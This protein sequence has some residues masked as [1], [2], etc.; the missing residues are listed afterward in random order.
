[1]TQRHLL[2]RALGAALVLAVTVTASVGGGGPANAAEPGQ[3]VTGSLAQVTHHTVTLVTGDVVSL[4][5]SA[6]GNQTATVK[7]GAGRSHIGF[8][9]RQLRGDLYVLP[10]DA[11]PL[12]SADRLDRELF[13]ITALVAD[14]FDDARSSGLPLIVDYPERR[15]I[16][17]SAPVLPGVTG[18][19]TLESIN[20]R[21]VTA[22]KAQ[23]RTLWDALSGTAA[24]GTARAAGGAVG[25]VWLSRRVQVTLER[26]VPQVGA[27]QVWDAGYDGTGVTVAI[28][29]TGVD[30]THPDLDGLPDGRPKVVG[31]ANFSVSADTTD[32]HGHGTHV[33]STVAGT[34]EAN[35][36]NR[37]GVAPAAKLLNA[38]VLDD[39]GNGTFDG[40]I[41]GLEWAAAQGADV[42]NMSIGTNAPATGADPMT[43]A[44]DAISRSS[45]MLVVVAAGNIGSGESTI[46]SPGWA[47]EALTVGAV[48]KLDKLAGFSS[49]GPRLGD[50]AIKPDLT[51]PGVGIVAARAAGTSRGSVVDQWYT[52]LD[53]TSMA[54]P[55]VAGAAALLAQ[56]FPDHTNRQLKD[57]L[58]S[59]SRTI[60][61]Q[62]VYQQ[63]GGRVDVARA[64]AQ[65]VTATPG[66]LNLGHFPYPHTDQQPVTR[67]VTY[68]NSGSSALTLALSL[69]IA[70]KQGKAAPA[71]MFAASAST[72]TVP[73]GGTATVDITVDPNAGPPEL[74]GGYLVGTADGVTVHTTV[75][76]YVEP[77][78]YEVTV[79][80][81]A[82]D[83]RPASSFS[84]IELWN[85]RTDAVHDETLSADGR[86]TFRVPPGV[87]SLAGFLGTADAANRY[88][89]EMSLVAQPQLTVSDDI[90]LTL[91]ARQATEVVVRTPQ[92]TEV[93][94]LV[95]AYHRGFGE[96]NLQGS[97]LAGRPTKRVFAT[98][99]TPV[100]EG[101]FEFLVRQARFAPLTEAAVTAPVSRSLNPYL[102]SGS[103]SIDGSHRKRLQSAGEGRPADYA[104]LDVR[105]KVVLVRR[106]SAIS[107]RNQADAAAAAGAWALMIANNQPG[108]L[109][110]YAGPAGEVPLPV[111]GIEQAEGQAL[112][113]LLARGPV[114]V[115]L[116]G[117]P[118]SPYGYHVLFAEQQRIPATLTYKV[119]HR[120]TAR[121]DSDFHGTSSGR[122]G[123]DVWHY[124][125]PYPTA[126]YALTRDMP[127]P[128]RRIDWLTT[129]DTR[130][131]HEVYAAPS[132]AGKFV[133]DW[134][135]YRSGSRHS[136]DWLRAI[137]RPSGKAGAPAVTRTGDEFKMEI[138]PF[139]DS[140]GHGGSTATGDTYR[141]TWYAGDKLLRQ[142][143]SAPSG[144][145]PAVGDPATYRLVLDGRRTAAW[146]PYAT[147]THTEWTFGSQRP[148]GTE[149]QV[150]G[151]LQVS[152]DLPLD[153]L[154]QAPD[155]QVYAFQV[156]VDQQPGAADRRVTDLDVQVSYDDGVTWRPALVVHR[157]GRAQ[158]LVHHPRPAGHTGAVSV[159]VSATDA[160]GARVEQVV[161]RAYGLR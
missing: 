57:Q 126:S 150:P 146:A 1:M 133:K 105:G 140:D 52:S 89:L 121:V 29:D 43:R 148:A 94:D 17:Q 31:A 80:G 19:Y 143:T 61:G 93:H 83:G 141:T 44:V 41:E 112:T 27:P 151:M 62:T 82:R 32:R 18:R 109:L 34:G 156:R 96:N 77:E 137:L 13:N 122:S 21:S 124:A 142:T 36:S 35:G 81:I 125:R 104:G 115:K 28:L 71:G 22:P 85:L 16:A 12:I 149:T 49:R 100:T 59:T 84:S 8:R 88:L 99:T 106:S 70:D 11:M 40:I 116:S 53:G 120:N 118:V 114:T 139:V 95:V 144:A 42:A 155:S 152:Y 154:N 60:A 63:G 111:V 2:R 134:E 10:A 72:V 73:A 91:D 147:S 86:V 102:M 67:T 46:A 138:Y 78:L 26:S 47:D 64:A 25:K 3:P 157:D 119:D 48:T 45:G 160:G 158:V 132:L 24:A 33:A 161:L 65:P 123:S 107:F 87:Y 66:T 68:G 92:P 15:G 131:K 136:D 117:T 7:P 30:A 4:Q 127:L 55:H 108:L 79:D 101:T 14:G 56:K 37:R 39:A 50:L 135:Q 159:K 58:I 90:T 54:T 51:A 129:G 23:A 145:F 97:Y 38:K 153:N 5:R 103:P 74:Y 6:D 20:A 130:W 9:T 75:G 69:Q 110:G 98:P 128:S 76:A 113:E